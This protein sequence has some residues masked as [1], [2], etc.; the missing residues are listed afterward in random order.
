MNFSSVGKSYFYRKILKKLHLQEKTN[1]IE[2][3][4]FYWNCEVIG[5]K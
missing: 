5:A 3:I 1:L 4:Q 2:K